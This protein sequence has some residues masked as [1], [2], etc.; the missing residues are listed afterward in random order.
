MLAHSALS[1]I[2]PNE[3]NYRVW[4]LCRAFCAQT[5]ANNEEAG[6]NW[7]NLI[8]QLIPDITDDEESMLANKQAASWQT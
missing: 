1:L 2:A 8:A 3:N 7:G 4:V 5:A 6:D